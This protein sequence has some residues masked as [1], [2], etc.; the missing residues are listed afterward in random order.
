MKRLI[1][2]AFAVFCSCISPG[3]TGKMNLILGGTGSSQYVFGIL[4]GEGM[5]SQMSATKSG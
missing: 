4:S 5:L 3:A 1:L 2:L